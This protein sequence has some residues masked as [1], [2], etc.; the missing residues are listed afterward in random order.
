[1]PR[2]ILHI[3]G[4][5]PTNYFDNVSEL[6]EYSDLVQTDVL[7]T[8]HAM[9]CTDTK[10]LC[11]L[12]CIVTNITDDNIGNILSNKD[13]VG[14]EYDKQIK[15]DI[16]DFMLTTINNKNWG[17]ENINNIKNENKDVLICN[18][19]TGVSLTHPALK[20]NYSGYFKDFINNKTVPYD[21]NGHGTHCMGI[22]CGEENIG[23]SPNAQWMAIKAINNNGYS[24]IST[25][26][27][28][29]EWCYTYAEKK[30]DIISNSWGTN[31]S[32]VLKMAVDGCIQSGICLV[33]AAGN[34]GPD[35][36]IDLYPASYDGVISV[37]ATD[38]NNNIADFSSRGENVVCA[39]PGA[40]ILSAYKDGKYA[41][42]SGTSMACPHVAGLI[43]LMLGSKRDVSIYTKINQ[44]EIYNAI[45]FTC[46][47]IEEKGFDIKSGNGLID[48]RNC[49]DYFMGTSNIVEDDFNSNDLNGGTGWT[50]NWKK[51]GQIEIE[52]KRVKCISHKSYIERTV[53]LNNGSSLSFWTKKSN[54]YS[55]SVVWIKNGNINDQWTIL[56]ENKHA[57]GKTKQQIVNV[58]IPKEYQ[59]NVLF[60]FGH[61]NYYHEKYKYNWMKGNS[62]YGDIKIT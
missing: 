33:A 27:L 4:T 40:K 43:A 42:L 12:N 14:I 46:L 9:K 58:Q 16:N 31:H 19:D 49:V 55:N 57:H 5:K 24:N 61:C 23:V 62:Y 26:A 51:Y 53:N 28:A 30:P 52:N 38:Q 37:A 59:N 6:L 20:N 36:S 60:A 41:Y 25:L 35:K 32:D 45:K 34:E 1:M 50:D 47:D 56:W 8:L 54:W 48:V 2:I 29:L 7:N 17:L 13:V 10:R 3:N 15:L 39:G 44:E 11:A 21:D 18:I 22:A